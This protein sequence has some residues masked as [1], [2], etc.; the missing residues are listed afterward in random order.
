MFCLVKKRNRVN[1]NEKERNKE[2]RNKMNF[3]VIWFERNRSKIEKKE[4]ILEIIM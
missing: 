2:R 3:W 1:K 4:K